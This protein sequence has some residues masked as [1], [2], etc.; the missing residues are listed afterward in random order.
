M[1]FGNDL[2]A[3]TRCAAGWP[4][5]SLEWDRSSVLHSDREAVAQRAVDAVAA[6]DPQQRG[7]N[8]D[9]VENAARGKGGG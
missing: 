2:T 1:N 5:R 7:L 6:D 4:W 8:K 3:T 9:H